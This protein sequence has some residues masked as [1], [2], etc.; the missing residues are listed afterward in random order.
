[1]KVPTAQDT[2]SRSLRA[3]PDA[4]TVI[5]PEIR[6]EYRTVHGYRRAYRI[7]GSGPVVVLIHGI[8]DNS[9]TW[10]QIIGILA[11][12]HTVIA[13][14][15]L[16][17]GQSDKPRADYSVAAFANG[18]RDL[19][20]V[21]GYEQVTVVGHSLGGGVAMQ[22]CY[23]FPRMVSRLVLVAAGGVTRDVSPALR[24]AS[25]PFAPQMLSLLRFP[26][27]LALVDRAAQLAAATP[28]STRFPTYSPSYHFGDHPDLIR[29]LSGLTDSSA[30]AAFQRTLRS[31]VDWRGQIVTMLDRSYLTAL[32]P[33]LI[34][35]GDEDA[36]I[37]YQHALLAHAAIGHS[38]LETFSG[39]GHF[40]FRD[41]P[42]RFADLITDFVSTTRATPFDAVAWRAM[43]TNGRQSTTLA[44]DVET[45]D[46]VLEVLDAERS[47]T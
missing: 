16:G 26:G 11:H 19:L 8:G 23:Q 5:E 47:A 36:V 9:S 13:P 14:D 24:A 43:L 39:S 3:V 32:V 35:W 4:D 45:V 42:K 29:I 34:V 31:V 6:V 7:A 20:S 46:A 10:D 40:P 38:R 15:L 17:H 25:L 18:I 22:F 12:D 41:D 30:R 21:L 33:V 37:P 27:A 44:G 2:T 28:V 1:M